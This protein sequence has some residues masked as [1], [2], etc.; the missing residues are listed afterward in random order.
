MT[1]TISCTEK[2][3]QDEEA[4]FHMPTIYSTETNEFMKIDTDVIEKIYQEAHGNSSWDPSASFVIY[5]TCQQDC[6]IIIST[7][8]NNKYVRYRHLDGSTYNVLNALSLD[9]TWLKVHP[10]NNKFAYTCEEGDIN[11]DIN[12]KATVLISGA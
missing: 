4:S 6:S 12:I 3:Y 8:T 1:I 2:N 10:G 7:A 5:E 9:S 11:V